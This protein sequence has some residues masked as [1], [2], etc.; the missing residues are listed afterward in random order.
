MTWVGWKPPAGNSSTE[1]A[2]KLALS[3]LKWIS[4]VWEHLAVLEQEV[5]VG[6]P[7][8]GVALGGPGIA[9]VDI[10]PVHFPGA[11][12]SGRPAASAST[13]NTFRS[14]RSRA[15]SMAITMASGTRPPPQRGPLAPPLR[16]RR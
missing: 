9:E 16:S 13:K 2:N 12:K 8:L 15:C 11:K 5:P 3:V 1:K 4:P 7:P 6:Q 10:E 14:P